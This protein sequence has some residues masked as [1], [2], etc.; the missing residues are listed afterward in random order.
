[1]T[2]RSNMIVVADI[3]RFVKENG[4]LS[5]KKIHGILM[6]ALNKLYEYKR[7]EEERK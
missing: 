3:R 4:D 2:L 1:M 6:D 5:D 7:L